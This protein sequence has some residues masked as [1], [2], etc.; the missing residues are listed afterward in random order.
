MAWAGQRGLCPS[1]VWAGL[2]PG[3]VLHTQV[4]P[5]WV[6]FAERV[7]RQGIVSDVFRLGQPVIS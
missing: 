5:W 1:A 6:T 3:R 2:T 4:L 7:I